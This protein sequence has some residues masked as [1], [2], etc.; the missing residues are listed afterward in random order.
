MAINLDVILIILQKAIALRNKLKTAVIWP[1]LKE[2]PKTVI[3]T[4]SVR[5]RQPTNQL[6]LL[7][8]ITKFL[9]GETFCKRCCL[10]T[11]ISAELLFVIPTNP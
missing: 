3:H 9:L 1:L 5:N 6:K 8:K 2:L 7:F 11:E 4:S 10:L